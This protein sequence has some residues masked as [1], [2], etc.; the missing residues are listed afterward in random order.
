MKN[1]LLNKLLLVVLLVG[2][3]QLLSGSAVAQSVADIAKQKSNERTSR[4][5]TNDDMP[6]R[7]PSLDASSDTSQADQQATDDRK[8]DEKVAPSGEQSA[9]ADSPQVQEARHVVQ[10]KSVQIDAVKEEIRKMEEQLRNER[11]DVKAQDLQTS[12]ANLQHNIEVWN[13]QRDS[14]QQVIDSAEKEKSKQ[15]DGQQSAPLGQNS[16]SSDQ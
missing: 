15:K 6:T 8:A 7:V 4:V 16:N 3:A 5:I 12:I 2:A 14:A 11:D 9:S 10:A 13:T 1:T